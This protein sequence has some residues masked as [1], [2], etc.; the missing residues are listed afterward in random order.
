[1]GSV[2]PSCAP[3]SYI[4][5]ATVLAHCTTPLMPHAQLPPANVTPASA[6]GTAAPSA[7]RGS[8]AGKHT[9][10]ANNRVVCCSVW[11][12]RTQEVVHTLP[13]L[14]PVTSIRVSVPLLSCWHI[15][16]PA[17]HWLQ[18]LVAMPASSRSE[19]P[20][21][22]RQLPGAR[23]VLQGLSLNGHSVAAATDSSC[24]PAR[25]CHTVQCMHPAALCQPTPPSFAIP[26]TEKRVA[27][28]LVEL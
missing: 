21:H 16:E 7:V 3:W 26:T 11:D 2:L 8:Q 25:L 9:L 19:G 22:R 13:T 4:E 12:V 1:M 28:K 10:A 20:G 18:C 17:A 6:S 27:C 14:G 24:I 23:T 15:P 5:T